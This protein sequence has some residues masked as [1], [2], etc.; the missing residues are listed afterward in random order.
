MQREEVIEERDF[1]SVP[2]K[3]LEFEVS[4]QGVV[5]GSTC[6]NLTPSQAQK[7]QHLQVVYDGEV[8]I[9]NFGTIATPTEG[10]KANGDS[11]SYLESSP[12]IILFEP[13]MLYRI[14]EVRCCLKVTN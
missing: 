11:M 8:T 12:Q 6:L 5:R 4:Q 13:M 14:S 10:L 3:D 2:K 9:W 1:H 7:E